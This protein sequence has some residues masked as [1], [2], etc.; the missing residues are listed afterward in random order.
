VR[1]FVEERDPEGLLAWA[2]QEP[3]TG[4]MILALAFDLDDRRRWRAIEALGRWSA[5]VS[6]HD[7]EP[8]RSLIRRVLWLMNDESGGLAWHGPEV[9]GEIL[10]N[11]PELLPEYGRIVA[12]F[13]HE[14]PFGPG[15]CWALARLAPLSPPTFK[16]YIE[17]LS[18]LVADA[19]ADPVSRGYGLLALTV[20]RPGVA[21]E[22]AAALRNERAPV[23]SFDRDLGTSAEQTLGSLAQGISDLEAA[24]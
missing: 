22:L 16:D 20:L 8:V 24:A 3:D 19:A 17:D 6:R 4:I 1:T 18:R 11:V 23:W 12:S 10:A 7:P 21:R 2:R 13:L 15:V 14:E 5:E 9:L